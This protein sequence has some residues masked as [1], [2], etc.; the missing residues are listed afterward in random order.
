M[1][2]LKDILAYILKVYPYKNDLS[3]ARVTKMVYLADWHQAIKRG[4]Q[5]S[6]INWYFDNYGPYVWDVYNEAKDNTE[7]FTCRDSH[8]LFGEPKIQLGIKDV[9]FNPQLTAEEKESIDH[10]IA[11]TKQLN[12]G[13]FI[14]LIYS[15][16]PIM[17]SERYSR[18]N[19]IEKAAAYKNA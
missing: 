17:S 19:L 4:H 15:T 1:A 12:W 16:F 8:N 13:A 2:T 9:Q 14:R 10:V 5:V 11:T 3:N 6:S 18:L 7:L